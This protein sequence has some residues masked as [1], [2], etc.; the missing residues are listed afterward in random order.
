M[1][2]TPTE[3]S[4][5]LNLYFAGKSFQ[6]ISQI[7]NLCPQT[8][9]KYLKN[10][11][12]KREHGSWARKYS[13]DENYFEKI[14]SEEKAYWLGFLYA[15]GCVIREGVN[16]TLK[17][18]E[19]EHLNKYKKSLQ[20]NNK[21][22]FVKGIYYHKNVDR[23]IAQNTAKVRIRSK[24]MSCDLTKL[25]CIPRKTFKLKFPTPEQVPEEFLNHFIRGYFD[26]D[27]SIWVGISKA[28]GN[29]TCGCSITSTSDLLERLKN[30]FNFATN[31]TFGKIR[32][33]PYSVGIG[34]LQFTSRE[35]IWLFRDFL[36][37]NATIYLQRKYDKFEKIPK[38][39]INL[40]FVK[41]KQTILDIFCK[42]PFTISR[43]DIVKKSNL[44]SDK[45]QVIIRKLLKENKIQKISH[46]KYQ[47]INEKPV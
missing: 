3:K 28:G 1:I 47:F 35:A 4:E 6:E 25:G 5:M 14:D 41:N 39:S 40:Q 21:I 43:C 44:P 12:P 16:L 36:Y 22:E 2:I 38:N 30:Y 33:H 15:D 19:V 32:N 9:S 37:N 45:C 34:I 27:G 26:G 13:C 31:T 24:K 18:D 10:E 29:I 20:S 11:I 46:G 8:V 23:E 42:N 17:Y 7:Y